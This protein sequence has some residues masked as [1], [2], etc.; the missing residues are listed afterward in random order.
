[1][2][3]VPTAR[4]SAPPESPPS[5][6]APGRRPTRRATL[7]AAGAVGLTAAVAACGGSEGSDPGDNAPAERKP[8]AEGEEGGNSP[9]G[10]GESGA[11][12][13][14]TADIPEGGGTVFKDEGVV[15]TQP[16]AGQ[17]RAFSAKCTHQ[18]CAVKDVSGG[19]INCPCH[20]SRFDVSDGGVQGG[21]ATRPL[22]AAKISVSGGAIRLA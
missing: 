20:N 17:F 10:G 1:M 9:D 11:V 15:V 8:D 6:P 21:P 16:T 18:G 5:A 22:P 4:R 13:A 19:A 12:L 3:D 7:A 14:R 2:T